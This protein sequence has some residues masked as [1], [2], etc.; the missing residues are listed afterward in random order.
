MLKHV[1]VSF[2]PY[3]THIAAIYI[4][5][6]SYPCSCFWKISEL[7]VV[8]V[9]IKAMHT[10]PSPYCII[11]WKRSAHL[12]ILWKESKTKFLRKENINSRRQKRSKIVIEQNNSKHLSKEMKPSV[13]VC[14][15]VISCHKCTF[16]N[17]LTT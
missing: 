8:V 17:R 11:G 9:V 4:Y 7:V 6:M 1:Y 16:L 14:E 5:L 12:M 3:H 2:H 13:C 10:L 15:F